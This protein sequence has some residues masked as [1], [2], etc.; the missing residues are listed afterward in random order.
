VPLDAL[1]VALPLLEPEHELLLVMDNI[2][3]QLEDGGLAVSVKFASNKNRAHQM[4]DA[5]VFFKRDF[6]ITIR[7]FYASLLVM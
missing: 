5:N 4:A 6:I 3:L 7:F 1:A 2:Q